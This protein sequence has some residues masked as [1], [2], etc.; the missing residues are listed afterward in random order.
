MAAVRWYQ[1]VVINRR[2]FVQAAGA[3]GIAAFSLG[4][5]LAFSTLPAAY[6]AEP[7]IVEPPLGIPFLHGYDV[8]KSVVGGYPFVTRFN[9]GTGLGCFVDGGRVSGRPWFNIG[10]QD[11][12]PT[13][14]WW[15]TAGLDVDYDYA[16][17]WNGPASLRLSGALEPGVP[18]EAKLYKTKLEVAS[19]V[20]L[21]VR[22]RTGVAHAA[23]NLRLGLAFED[24]PGEITWLAAGRT[25]GAGWN[26]RHWRL[27]PY[28]GRTI[29]A[30]SAGLSSPDAVASHTVWLG[31]LV[32]ERE[33]DREAPKRPTG[34][35][36]EQAH[37]GDGTATAYLAWELETRD[38]WYYDLFRVWDGG[39]EWL[40][41]TYDEVFV[42]PGLTRRGTEPV[43][44]LELIAVSRAGVPSPGARAALR[45]S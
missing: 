13:W 26:V 17:A 27:G 36:V 25:G 45:W 42:V 18:L 11:V 21:S 6:A 22:Y 29:A 28:A 20:T 15:K 40:G 35:R 34:F 23:S 1:S 14:Q 32:L 43:T 24:A 41:R 44:G 31:E 2:R 9:T 30:V 39:R 3:A 37:F 33:S 16:S 12:L 8:E 10:V 5:G 4:D 19:D 38:V 7:A